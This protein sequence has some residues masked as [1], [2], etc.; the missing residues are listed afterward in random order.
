MERILEK[1]GG[2]PDLRRLVRNTL[3]VMYGHDFGLGMSVQ[4]HRALFSV[5]AKMGRVSSL[6][7]RVLS[8]VESYYSGLADDVDLRGFVSVGEEVFGTI[9][10]RLDDGRTMNISSS[11]ML[12]FRQEFR[13]D[14]YGGSR[15]RLVVRA[16]LFTLLFSIQLRLG[17]G[18][19]LDAGVRPL[20]QKLLEVPETKSN[21]IAAKLDLFTPI[22]THAQI[23]DF[24]PGGGAT[25]SRDLEQ[26]EVEDRSTIT[27][28]LTRKTEVFYSS[29]RVEIRVGGDSA[30]QRD[31]TFET[32]LVGFANYFIDAIDPAYMWNSA[33][34]LSVIVSSRN[35]L[36]WGDLYEQGLRESDI[37]E[38]FYENGTK[39][40]WVHDDPDQSPLYILG[41][42]GHEIAHRVHGDAYDVATECTSGKG[43]CV[44][45]M[46][47]VESGHND[48]TRLNVY[49]NVNEAKGV[50]YLGLKSENMTPDEA[51]I[52][53][54]AH[55]DTQI[56]QAYHN[57]KHGIHRDA[58][59]EFD[60][61]DYA[62]SSYKEFWAEASVAFLLGR[63][64]EQSGV[65]RFPHHDWIQQN[66]PQLFTTLEEVYSGVSIDDMSFAMFLNTGR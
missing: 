55:L 26:E 38:G 23:F 51:R 56:L 1:T 31:R 53:L 40:I 20:R 66:D 62:M 39:H 17:L 45:L 59:A 4:S 22:W 30:N 47:D 35:H 18:L 58:Y 21:R 7:R 61:A 42:L 50:L 8:Y 64:V 48:T 15:Y 29:D 14:S 60:G 28:A 54:K 5:I 11:A 43:F 33:E 12:S 41:I 32:N 3:V 24:I 63:H 16:L 37:L 10:D 44:N 2:P 6:A 65:A 25:W 57:A 36:P 34:K 9:P 46:Y 19:G 27:E 52:Y 13:P 49:K